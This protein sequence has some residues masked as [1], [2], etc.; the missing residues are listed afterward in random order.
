MNEN[1]Q[2]IRNTNDRMK[3]GGIERGKGNCKQTNMY[4]VTKNSLF[5]DEHVLA[6]GARLLCVF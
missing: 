6:D 3:A 5:I 2:G 4:Q 1:A